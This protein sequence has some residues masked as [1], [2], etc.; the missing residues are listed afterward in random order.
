MK[1][2]STQTTH[3]MKNT[4]FLLHIYFKKTPLYAYWY[5]GDKI[6][7][8]VGIFLEHTLAVFMILTAVEIGRPFGE[9]AMWLIALFVFEIFHMGLDSY[10]TYKLGPRAIPVLEQY[11]KTKLFARAKVLDLES[12]DNPSFYNDYIMAINESDT[13]LHRA[14]E[15][16]IRLVSAI[17]RIVLT[18]GFILFID[19][20][21]FGF[22]AM[23]FALGMA[24]DIAINKLTFKAQLETVPLTRKAGYIGRVFYLPDYAKEMRLNAKAVPHFQQELDSVFTELGTVARKY[25]GKQVV[26]NWLKNYV[27]SDFI[28]TTLFMVYLIYA[29]IVLNTLSIASIVV[30]FGS[31]WTLRWGLQNISSALTDVAD[32]SR[33]VDRIK[34]FL[35]KEP[36]IKSTADLPVDTTV[37][38]LIEFKDVSF[39]YSEQSPYVLE[40]INLRIE[41]GAKTAI[42][43]YN[44]AGKSTLVK[45]IMRLYDP[46]EGE[47]LLN[48]VNIKAYA[49]DAY[50]EAI[51]VIFQDFK[52]FAG[53]VAE[54]VLLERAENADTVGVTR[55]LAKAGFGERLAGYEQGLNQQLTTEFEE[56][57]V[58]LSGGEA[59]KIAT[60]R[61]FY[62]DAPLIIL[63]EPSSALD[64]IAEY[65]F[66]ETL[67][68]AGRNK[69]MIFISHRLSTTRIS[70][71]IFMMEQGRVVEAGTH[72]ELLTTG[73]K[74]ADMWEAQTARYRA[75]A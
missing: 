74:Y 54:N 50:R 60:A 37:P 1:K 23:V 20:V 36:S 43:G 21:A 2:N 30:L 31:T 13:Q 8:E 62:K 6:R 69:T 59:Q 46:S 12:Y 18:G 40:K 45:L 38:A 3:H 5:L 24:T 17:T 47:V 73:G 44:G 9:V 19:P 55:A 71:Y 68:A 4:W 49:V 51:G 42:V 22:V 66:N 26:L 72:D 53:S 15:V 75:L 14:M 7:N 28:L 63:D 64:P 48:G 56:T 58:N 11:L 10:R 41:A 39:R 25:A 61:A 57:G 33:Y 27:F 34:L 70:D 35:D 16:L 67:T 52:I 65:H 29:A 32:I